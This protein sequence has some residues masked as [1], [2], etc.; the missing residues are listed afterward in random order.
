MVLSISNS[1]K[2]T[3]KKLMSALSLGGVELANSSIGYNRFN[4]Y[5]NHSLEVEIY[6]LF[7]TKFNIR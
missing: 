1:V 5:L 4:L 3:R 2:V 6:I 7:D